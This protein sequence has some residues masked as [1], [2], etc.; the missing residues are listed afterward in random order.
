M[1]SFFGLIG[2]RNLV[3]PLS[4]VLG[5]AFGNR[6]AFLSDFAVFFLALMMLISTSGIPTKSLL[7]FEKLRRDLFWTILLTYIM[8]GGLMI[9]FAYILLPE[10]DYFTGFVLLAASPAGIANIAF[11]LVLKG[12]L[13]LSVNSV[14][15]SSLATVVAVPLAIYLFIGG[16][17]FE[18]GGMMLLLI[19]VT[20]IPLFLSRLLQRGKINR[21]ISKGR[22][23]IVNWSL[24]FLILP[25][26]GGNRDTMF[27]QPY[28]VIMISVVF[29]LVLFLGGIV[30]DRFLFHF[31]FPRDRIISSVLTMA[32][33]N[34]GFTVVIAWTY[35][36]EQ[37][38]LP[39]AV[40]AVF[41]I[42]FF[43]FYSYFTGKVK[44]TT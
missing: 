1:K 44:Y 2:H 22:G 39:A 43:F 38:A 8:G 11:T 33:K 24:F 15:F 28:G 42:L 16:S 4:L 29:I 7:S 10:T 18:V 30:V 34:G 5:F 23:F 26:I 14:I 37:A 13:E 6:I 25:A 12:E 20:V 32:L 21:V 41:L 40:L 9:V 27:D 35:F 19:G 17:A 36:S 3:L 31:G